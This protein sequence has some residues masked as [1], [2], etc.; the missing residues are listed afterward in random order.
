VHAGKSVL[1]I[2]VAGDPGDAQLH[3]SLT[4]RAMVFFPQFI[5]FFFL[6]TVLNVCH[7]AN[8]PSNAFFLHG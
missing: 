4:H 1:G 5:F 6:F 2:Q 3:S 7:L 8:G